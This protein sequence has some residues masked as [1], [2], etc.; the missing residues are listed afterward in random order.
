MIAVTIS[1]GVTPPAIPLLELVHTSKTAIVAIS[2][3]RRVEYAD[4]FRTDGTET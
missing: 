2:R 1:F 4:L 3:R